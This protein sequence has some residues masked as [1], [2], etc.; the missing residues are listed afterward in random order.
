MRRIVVCVGMM[1]LS[2]ASLAIGADK[3]GPDEAAIR[4]AVESYT[5]AYNRGDAKAVP[6]IGRKPP[7]GSVRRARKSK[8]APRSNRR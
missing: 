2:L 7:N 5:A 6:A 3:P 4:A 8:G 1:W